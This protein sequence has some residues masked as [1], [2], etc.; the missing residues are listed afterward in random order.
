MIPIDSGID[1]NAPITDAIHMLVMT[2]DYS[3]MVT[4]KGDV[5]GILRL[6][7]VFEEVADIIRCCAEAGSNCEECF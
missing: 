2:H 5:I 3:T 4:R 1:E 7:D 6:A